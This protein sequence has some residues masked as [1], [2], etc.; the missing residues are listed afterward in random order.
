MIIRVL[1]AQSDLLPVPI[2]APRMSAANM[3]E[4]LIKPR[5]SGSTRNGAIMPEIEI[6][7]GGRNN[8]KD[9]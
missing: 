9:E 7:A 1:I 8:G 5:S 4:R 2:V 6:S 3:A